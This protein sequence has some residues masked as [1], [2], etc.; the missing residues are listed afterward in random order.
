MDSIHVLLVGCHLLVSQLL[1][2]KD[3]G[4]LQLHN[5]WLAGVQLVLGL[6]VLAHGTQV[7]HQV[8]EVLL[9]RI[10]L[11]AWCRLNRMLVQLPLLVKLLS[12]GEGLNLVVDQAD[13]L[14]DHVGE[15]ALLSLEFLLALVDDLLLDLLVLTDVGLHV[16]NRLDWPLDHA[17]LV[18]K[19]SESKV[20]AVRVEL[21]RLL[22]ELLDRLMCEV[23]RV[24]VRRVT[25]HTLLLLM[26][27]LVLLLE[28][29]LLHQNLGHRTLIDVFALLKSLLLHLE[30]LL[31]LLLILLLLKMCVLIFH[32][33]LLAKGG[34]GS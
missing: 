31:Q 25:D 10:L 17:L 27:R 34:L 1:S 4:L 14:R 5:V 28:I 22:I 18:L 12:G 15:L 20:L 11:K 6:L 30:V 24:V 16:T 32:G 19:L 23:G 8:H 33:T 3:A 29:L 21:L 9:M 13:L 7:A 26:Q 2:R